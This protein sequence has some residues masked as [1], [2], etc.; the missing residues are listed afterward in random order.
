MRVLVIGSFQYAIYAPAL[1]YGFKKLGHEVEIV[2][3]RQYRHNDTLIG[4][5]FN[6]IQGRYYIGTKLVAYNNDIVKTAKRFRPD[7]IF[8]YS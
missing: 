7:L 6:K 3:A 8:L 4:G 1:E 2:D 5:M